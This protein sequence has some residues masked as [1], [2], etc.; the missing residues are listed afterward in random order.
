MSGCEIDAGH[1]CFNQALPV[2]AIDV[3][4]SFILIVLL[5]AATPITVIFDGPIVHGL[6]AAT[7]AV[8]IA[9]ISRAIH[10]GEATFLLTLIRRAAI[11]VAAP[12]IWMLIQI[13]PLGSIGVSNP[14]WQGAETALGHP[15]IGGISIDPGATLLAFCNYVST[16]AIMLAVMAVTIDR[17]RAEWLLFALMATTT[18]VAALSIGHDL[19]EFTF[20]GKLSVSSATPAVADCTA[21][22]IIISAACG[23]RAIERYETRRPGQGTSALAFVPAIATCASAFS[24]C[25]LA[26]ALRATGN[27]ILATSFGLVTLAAVIVIRRFGLGPWGYSAIAA[28]ALVVLASIILTQPGLQNTDLTLAFTHAP[29]PLASI[30]RR[31][32]ADASWAGTGAGTF[33]DLIPIY[34]DLDDVIHGSAAPSAAATIAV[35]LG[36]PALSAAVAIAIVA[37][38][39]LLQGAL[40]RGRDSFYPAAGASSIVTLL[41]L[42]FGDVGLFATGVAI[43][44]AAI[45]GLAV[46]QSRSRTI[47]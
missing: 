27:Q 45:L 33:G 41:F 30:T 47:Q 40:R 9:I 11:V 2:G 13:L 22:G 23:I 6:V 8:A 36:R 25:S 46:A 20:L 42:A 17:R 21:L 15:V 31:I 34:R 5:V 7:G 26:L 4:A 44:T 12:A 38:V 35:E 43:I 37:I 24:I 32:L 10:P 14:I 16:V 28:V 1:T 29:A 18:L 19:G 3:F 39:W